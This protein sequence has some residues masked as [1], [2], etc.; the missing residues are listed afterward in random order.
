MSSS[1]RP[2]SL[3]VCVDYD[4]LLAVALSRNLPHLGETLVVSHPEDSRTSR[5][6]NSTPGVDL[7]VTDAFYRHGAKFNKGLAVEEALDYFGRRDWMLIWDADTLFPPDMELSNLSSTCLYSPYRLIMEE[8]SLYRDDWTWEQ[9][10]SVCKGT[11]DSVFAGYFQ[12]FHADDPHLA[13]RPWYDATF[14]HAGGC[15]GYFQTKWSPAEKVRPNFQVIHLGPRDTNWCGRI[16]SRLDG[17]EVNSKVEDSR[18]AM[19]SFLAYKGWYGEKSRVKFDENV[20]VPG[21]KPT[22]FVP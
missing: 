4:D 8:P 17:D 6:V 11:N 9:L 13:E 22:G 12:L 20:E 2:R 3:V 7:F 18:R 16:T 1:I 5:L 21:V 14:T 15:D 19:K 10:C